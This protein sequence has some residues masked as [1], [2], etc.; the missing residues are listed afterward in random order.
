MTEI[1]RLTPAEIR[2]A[3]AELEARAA[4][5]SVRLRG[6]TLSPGSQAVS[7]REGQLFIGLGSNNWERHCVGNVDIDTAWFDYWRGLLA[8]RQAEARRRGV[9]MWNVVVPEKQV[10]LP[11]L[12]WAEPPDCGMRPMGQ[13]LRRLGPEHRMYYAAPDLLAAKAQGPVYHVRDSHWCASGVLAATRGLLQA[14][15][16]TVDFDALRFAY[17][18]VRR[19]HDL[20]L[21]FLDAPI[22]VEAGRLRPNGRYA[23]HYDAREVGRHVGSQFRIVNP[24]APDPRRVGVCGD[25]Y[26]WEDGLPFALSGVFAE[27]Y[28]LWS[29]D[30]SWDMAAAERCDLLIW[31]SAERFISTTPGI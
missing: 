24:D 2:A 22:E 4:A 21:H 8:E 30:L 25:S 20:P 6:G 31:E 10:V 27:V 26:S 5:E 7:G 16:V 3:D 14:M 1:L 29:K 12:R 13:L 17:A 9:E 18:R 23:H 28:F 19:T 11:E 15:G